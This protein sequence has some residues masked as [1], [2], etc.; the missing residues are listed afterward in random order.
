MCDI[1]NPNFYD[2]LG[3]IIKHT[4]IQVYVFGKYAKLLSSIFNFQW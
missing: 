3:V 4:S 2:I 1:F